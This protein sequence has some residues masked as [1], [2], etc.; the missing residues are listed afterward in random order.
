MP[1]SL[2][3]FRFV[4]AAFLLCLTLAGCGVS[5]PHYTLGGSPESRVIIIHL[6]ETATEKI[7]AG[8][9]IG[10]GLTS[11]MKLQMSSGE[12]V[13]IEQDSAKV[14]MIAKGPMFIV[15]S[16]EYD[17]KKVNFHEPIF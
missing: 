7:P 1:C 6:S 2:L 3:P 14:T 11:E 5:Y 4:C 17:G 15:K 13:T 8:S 10:G 9:G 16:V 12:E